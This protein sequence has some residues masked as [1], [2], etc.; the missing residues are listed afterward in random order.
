MTSRDRDRWMD[1]SRRHAFVVDSLMAFCGVVTRRG[2]SPFGDARAAAGMSEWATRA[3]ALE[4]RA[5]ARERRM[6]A[7]G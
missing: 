1:P 5:E 4:R 7:E 2:V 6:E 3:R